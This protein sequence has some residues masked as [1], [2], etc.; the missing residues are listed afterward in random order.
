MAGHYL[1]RGLA[2]STRRSYETPRRSFIRF[3]TL[4]GRRHSSGSCLPATGRWLIEWITS[5]AGRVKVKTIKQYLS[6]LRSYHVDL[7]LPVVAFSDELLERVMRGIKRDH[8]EPDRRERTPLTRDHLLRILRKLHLPSYTSHTL[9]AAFTLAFAGFL[10]VGKFTY[11]TADLELGPHF[12]NWFLTKSSIKISRDRSHMS[13]YLPASKTDPFRHGVEIIVAATGDEAGAV[14]AMDEFLR[15]DPHRSPLAPLFVA[16][17]ARSTAFTR[18]Y[19]VNKLRALAMAAGLGA[20]TWNGHSFRR[21]A[22]TWAAEAG[23]AESQIQALGRWTSSAY[24][25]YIETSREDRI[26]LSHRFQQ[27]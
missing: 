16:D 18:E 14:R 1:W 23:I 12:R 21:G 3:C 24:K 15:A 27:A 5:L 10:R 20:A 13:V 25:S 26:A 6:G 2:Q 4:S 7:G 9:K 8:A 22:A 17:R 19:V 11:Q